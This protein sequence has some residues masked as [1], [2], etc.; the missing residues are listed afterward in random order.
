MLAC[1]HRSL[2][3][4]L[5]LW[6]EAMHKT[7]V[8]SLLQHYTS[9][10]GV[11]QARACHW[12]CESLAVPGCMPLVMLGVTGRDVHGSACCCDLQFPCACH[13]C[14]GSG[15]DIGCFSGLGC[16]SDGACGKGTWRIRQV[17]W[18]HCTCLMTSVCERIMSCG[19]WVL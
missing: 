10:M 2:S 16:Q 6:S 4:C 19:C 18:R 11:M 9:T 3:A 7:G 13:G 12:S 1:T 8:A 5:A 15:M 17:P 14:A